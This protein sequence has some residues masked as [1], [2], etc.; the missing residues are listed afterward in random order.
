MKKLWHDRAWEEYSDWQGRDKKTL[1]RIN[2]LL[3]SIDR[4]GYDCIGKPEPLKGDLTGWWSVRIDEANRIVFR[5]VDGVF[6]IYS[7]AGH[8][9]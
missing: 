6:E 1:K 9:E 3:K 2:N 4:D 7:C 5:L 8:Y